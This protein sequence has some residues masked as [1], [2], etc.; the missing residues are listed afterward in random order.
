MSILST[1]CRIF[2]PRDSSIAAIRRDTDPTDPEM[3]VEVLS[4]ELH[5]QKHP[6][7]LESDSVR[8][9]MPAMTAD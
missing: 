7:M 8:T 3:L 6:S 2:P 1:Q 4:Q 5:A 9:N